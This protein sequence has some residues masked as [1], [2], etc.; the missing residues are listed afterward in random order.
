MRLSDVRNPDW[1]ILRNGTFASLGLCGARAGIPLL[2]FV[3]NEKYLRVAKG[4]PDVSALLI[5]PSLANS[6]ELEGLSE[7]VGLAVVPELRKDFF[8]LHNRLA[9]EKDDYLAADFPTRIDP[10]ASVS[11]LAEIGVKNIEIGA[12]VTIEAFV[13]IKENTRIGANSILRSGT[14]LGGTGLEFMRLDAETILPVTHCGWLTIGTNV[15]IQYN[16]N[17][18]R[19]LFPWHETVIGDDSKIESLV[20][21]AHGVHIGKRALIAAGAVIGGSAILGDNV[22]IGPNATVSSEV[23]I[24]DQARVSLGAVVVGNVRSGKTVSG[25]FAFEH[26]KFLTDQLK[27]MVGE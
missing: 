10:S 18:S 16:C 27:R 20:H 2:S 9:D 6:P 23:K 3:G 25:N 13:S 5:P 12:N 21:I 26:D 17:V 19:S 7:S 1:T 4:N 14:V 11:P 15:E 8:T 22:W 24:G